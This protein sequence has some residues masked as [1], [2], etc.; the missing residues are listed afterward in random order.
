[1][2]FVGHSTHRDRRSQR[3]PGL[4]TIAELLRTLRFTWAFYGLR[5]LGVMEWGT[6]WAFR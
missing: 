6:Y 1:M 3:S 2:G 4:V 5:I